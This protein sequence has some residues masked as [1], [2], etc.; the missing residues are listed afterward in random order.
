MKRRE[1]WAERLE[2]FLEAR[3]CYLSAQ[4]KPFEWGTNDCAMFA[5]DAVQEMTGVDLAAEFRGYGS[6]AGAAQAMAEYVRGRSIPPGCETL[7]EAVAVLVAREHGLEEIEPGLAQRGDVVL[8]RDDA[9]Q[10]ALGVMGF[11]GL[12]AVM[13]RDGAGVVIGHAIDRAWR[14]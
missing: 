9:G 2:N 6:E 12:L 3:G 8:L 14:V 7:L 10:H 1:D 11:D 13:R 4:Q 5:C